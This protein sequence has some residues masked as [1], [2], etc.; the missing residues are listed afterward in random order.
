MLAYPAMAAGDEDPIRKWSPLTR[1]VV[2][3]G[4]FV[5][6]RTASRWYLRR[7]PS[8][9]LRAMDVATERALTYAG[10]LSEVVAWD[11]SKISWPNQRSSCAA[12]ARLNAM[13]S[14]RLLG[15]PCP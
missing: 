15:Y 5:G 3:A 7:V 10:S 11:C 2:Q 12:C 13:S 4:E 9:A 14:A 1:S 8:M 6:A